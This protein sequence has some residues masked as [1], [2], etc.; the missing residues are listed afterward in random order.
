M[1]LETA[2]SAPRPR[3][4]ARGWLRIVCNL[5]SST[6]FNISV[7]FWV[8]LIFAALFA[9]F[10]APYPPTN[11]NL[12]AALQPPSWSHWMGTDQLGRDVLSRIIWGARFSMMVVMSAVVLAGIIGTLL[13]V[14][15]GYVGGLFDAIV[16][17]FVDI[18]YSLPTII[19]A[20]VTISV[21]GSSTL[22][23]ILVITLTNWP[24]FAR[25]VR[26]EAWSIRNREFVVLAEL[27]GASTARIVWRH[28]LPNLVPTLIVL[29]TLDIG[30]VIL[31][32]AA[33]SFLGLGIQ[34]PNPS[35]GTMISDGRGHMEESWWIMA[36]PGATLMLAVLCIN[37]IGD[38]L[39]LGLTPQA[40]GGR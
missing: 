34:P 11:M 40:P 18:Q 5:A 36:A 8:M 6:S 38:R 9:P 24:R 21:F 23:L 39:R 1:T 37:I 17:R 27:G 26:G 32:E 4:P 2:A 16:M 12:G 31:L 25:I 19:L 13:G 14:V 29:F 28:I 15:A 3:A 20:I 35:W 22:N 7:L 10:V 33:L 30:M